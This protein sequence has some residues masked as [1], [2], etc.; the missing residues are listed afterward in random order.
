MLFASRLQNWLAAVLSSHC[1]C[2]AFGNGV[3]NGRTA[4]IRFENSGQGICPS[5]LNLIV[6]NYRLWMTKACS[7]LLRR[8]VVE[9]VV[10]LQNSF[11]VNLQQ[12][13]NM[14][15]ENVKIHC[16]ARLRRRG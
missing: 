13:F 14:C 1:L 4:S 12:G 15:D 7:Q 10:N 9:R 8:T 11:T 5:V 2:Q 6:D 16:N 3:V